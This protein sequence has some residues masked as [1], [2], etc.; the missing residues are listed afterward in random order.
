LTVIRSWSPPSKITQ[1][2]CFIV[3]F[4]IAGLIVPHDR[5]KVVCIFHIACHASFYIAK[6]CFYDC[7]QGLLFLSFPFIGLRFCAL[8]FLS[9]PIVVFADF[10]ALTTAFVTFA[11]LLPSNDED[12][13]LF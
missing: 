13:C 2:F 10:P 1:S 4:S 3:S 8:D 9:H 12:F 6:L 11:A 5:Y 7:L